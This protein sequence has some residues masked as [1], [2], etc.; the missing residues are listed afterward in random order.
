MGV[1]SVD[2][3]APDTTA[4]LQTSPT[5]AVRRVSCHARVVGASV[6]CTVP[7]LCAHGLCC[8]SFLLVAQARG[9][10]AERDGALQLR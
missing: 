10:G 7:P 4:A 5:C 3:M 2:M 6:S 8:H 9:A 1:T